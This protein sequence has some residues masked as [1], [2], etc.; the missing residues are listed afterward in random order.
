MSPMKY[1]DAMDQLRRLRE[2]SPIAWV[3]ELNAAL[4]TRH[5]DIVGVL[6]DR[7]MGPANLTQGMRLLPPDQQQELLPLR[8]AVDKWMG[9]TKPDDH[10]RFIRLLRHFF[11]PGVVESFRPRVREITNEM[12]DAAERL[13]V[14]DLVSTIAYPLPAAVISEMLGVPTDNKEQLLAWSADISAI[15]E[16]VSF[17]RLSSCQTSLL[18]MQDYMLELLRE[19][20]AAPRDDLISMFAKAES[21][22][23]V[24]ESEI[25]SNC[26]MLLFSGHETTGG[27][28]TNGL[29]QLFENPD[30]ME[31]LKSDPEL[32]PGAVEEMLRMAGPASVI[33]RVSEEP[34]AVAGHE[35]SAGQQFLLALNAA[36]RD[37]QVF[38]DPETFDVTR[39]P[40]PHI[41][42]A[43]GLFHCLG[44]ALARM[45]GDEFFRILLAR[46]PDVRPAYDEPDW[47]PT[48][49][50]SRRLK[51][52]PI[53]LTAPSARG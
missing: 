52:L 33:S 3:P 49:L 28:I 48:F 5:G 6:K 40:N 7:R 20:R 1:V 19:R 53:H 16:I 34:V 29:V 12:L 13:P 41:A 17:D 22:G 51:E 46:F 25:L 50:I 2:Q 31:L 9:H 23:V 39:S 4:L 43:T 10:Q 8:T 35:F 36:N 21:E 44:A 42:F 14:V 47:Q 30:Q 26:V 37:T 15:A 38:S 45:E 32:T 27:L 24:D 18:E 11:T